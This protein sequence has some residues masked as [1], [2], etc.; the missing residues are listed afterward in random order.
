[1]RQP[2]RSRSSA[3]TLIELLVVIAIIA[4]LV[5]ILLP[6]IGR[7]RR[8]ARLATCQS[9][10][11]QMMIAHAGYNADFKN[12][13]AAFNGR[14]EDYNPGFLGT[15]PQPWFP[16]GIDVAKQAQQLINEGPN[17]ARRYYLGTFSNNTSF[18]FVVEQYSHV[19]LSQ[20]LG[21]AMPLPGTVCPEDR[22]RLSWQGV[23]LNADLV[24]DTARSASAPRHPRNTQNMAWWAFSSS[25]QLSPQACAGRRTDFAIHFALYSQ[26]PENKPVHDQYHN[27]GRLGGQ[28][29][30]RVAF[31]SQKVALYDSQDRHIAKQELFFG[32]KE[33]RQP[34][35][36]FD[37][38]V[39]IRRT[40][41]ANPGHEHYNP[42][43]DPAATAAYT[44]DPD[45]GFESPVPS[46]QSEKIP[47]GYY[48]W[49]RGDLGGVD[50]GGGEIQDV[51]R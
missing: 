44:Y 45:P 39:S 38:S 23:P 24:P 47:A 21:G 9:N 5:A 13:I 10:M 30:T 8:A 43:R 27:K 12:F 37:G 51:K 1:M 15:G 11:R 28:K 20:Y 34:L 32:Y 31:P 50:F 42:Y 14:A 41:D 26:G 16:N 36:F 18:T 17:R 49:T 3:F 33:A 35:A 19:V 48:R 25:Y 6:A 22:A 7:A 2:L 40:G 29:I 46:D 4:L